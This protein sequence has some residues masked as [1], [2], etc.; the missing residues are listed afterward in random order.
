[1][2]IFL[3]FLLQLALAGAVPYADAQLEAEASH[4]S[5]HLESE[6]AACGIGH[7]HLFCILCRALDPV[8]APALPSAAPADRE[9]ARPCSADRFVDARANAIDATTRSPRAPPSA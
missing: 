4:A 7:D 9:P 3:L 2:E 5:T 6:A 1:M 8:Q